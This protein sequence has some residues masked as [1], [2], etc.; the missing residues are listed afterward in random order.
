MNNHSNGRDAFS[1]TAVATGFLVLGDQTG[2]MSFEQEEKKAGDEKG[3]RST[4]TKPGER[5]RGKIKIVKE[6]NRREQ[7]GG[8]RKRKLP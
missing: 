2:M 3:E 5:R 8:M 1:G 7:Q 6:G 4:K